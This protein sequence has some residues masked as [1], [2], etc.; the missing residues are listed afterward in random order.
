[1]S[2]K[3]HGLEI[4]TRKSIILFFIGV[5]GSSLM[6]FYKFLSNPPLV[7]IRYYPNYIFGAS[8]ALIEEFVIYLV[9]VPVVMFLLLGFLEPCCSHQLARV[10][11]GRRG[12]KLKLFQGWKVHARLMVPLIIMLLL[13][14]PPYLAFDT[15]FWRVSIILAVVVWPM[16]WL[17]YL[18]AD[19]SFRV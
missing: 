10:F 19:L 15:N 11:T 12:M 14:F 3:D 18:L 5:A 8:R 16:F 1:M 17:G 7:Q 6:I 13:L 9:A 4:S 2:A